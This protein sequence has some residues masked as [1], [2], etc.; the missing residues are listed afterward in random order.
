M[1]VG[2]TGA[3]GFL[4][5]HVCD[6][7]RVAGHDVAAV[8]LARP[9][10]Q[11]IIPGALRAL[12]HCAAKCGGIGFNQHWGYD[13]FGDNIWLGRQAIDVCRHSHYGNAKLVAVSSVCAYPNQTEAPF[14]E[15]AI[16]SG[17]PEETN[18]AYG[19]AKRLLLEQCRWAQER[20]GL[21]YTAVIPA[22]LYGPRDHT[23]PDRSHVIPAIIRAIAEAKSNGTDVT[24]W[25]SGAP[26]RDFLYVP[27][28][29]A[30]IVRAVEID[31]PRPINLGTGV[32]T[33]IHLLALT[34]ADLMG[35]HGEIKWDASKPNGQLRRCVDSSRAR[36]VLGWQATTSL[37]DGLRKTIE[38]QR[39]SRMQTKR[40]LIGARS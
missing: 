37:Q 17:Y 32:E 40:R 39:R 25:G 5:S 11:Q 30:A 35:Y 12:V 22:N 26:T 28:C 4:G 20:Y 24:L 27:D 16:W 10:K 36:K 34:I 8:R 13:L 14:R 31:D 21:C 2:V 18:A 3:K 6:A 19:L 1:L 7:L 15:G 23:E 33:S 29:A 9:G 38:W